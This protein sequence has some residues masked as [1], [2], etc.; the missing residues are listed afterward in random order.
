M[1]T[2][3]DEYCGL[4][5]SETKIWVK[6]NHGKNSIVRLKCSKILVEINNAIP[7]IVGIGT[8][9]KKLATVMVRLSGMVKLNV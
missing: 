5:P 1:A 3:G 9:T 6:I 7:M 4:F 2:A 8:N